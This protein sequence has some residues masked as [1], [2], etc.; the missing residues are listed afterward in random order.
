MNAVLDEDEALYFEEVALRLLK[1]KLVIVSYCLLR[2]RRVLML[3]NDVGN[4]K[5]AECD[6]F[7]VSISSVHY[8]KY[9]LS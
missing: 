9:I 1:T 6:Q 7:S 4:Q 3:F 2:A 5:D 8:T